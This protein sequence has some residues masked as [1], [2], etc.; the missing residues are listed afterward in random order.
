MRVAVT[1]RGLRDVRAE[2]GC[3]CRPAGSGGAAVGALGRRARPPES[4]SRPTSV[5]AP[6]EERFTLSP[7]LTEAQQVNGFQGGGE[8]SPP[9]PP[10]QLGGVQKLRGG[11]RPP[12]L[13][14][15]PRLT[16]SPLLPHALPACCS[17]LR[18]QPLAGTSRYAARGAAGG[19]GESKPSPHPTC[20]GGESRAGTG[21]SRR[22]R[23]SQAR[24][25][26][27]VTPPGQR[28]RETRA[29][30]PMPLV[31]NPRPCSR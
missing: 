20:P 28:G 10:P 18:P 6:P 25:R 21:E 7:L 1:W 8:R 9:P 15:A 13:P 3:R 5:T 14:H 23:S 16:P 11:Q 27:A 19:S 29:A 2:S 26:V 24:Q 4:R 17:R 30:E 22:R 31:F 12:L